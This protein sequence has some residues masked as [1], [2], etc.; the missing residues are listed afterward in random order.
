MIDTL[1]E[2]WGAIMRNKMRTAATGIAVASG[3]FLLIVLL[4]ASNGI[5]HTLE[6]N[7]EGLSLDAVHIYPGYTSK[8]FHG[9]KEGR[10]IELDDR[11]INMP[12]KRFK[13]NVNEVTATVEQS[14][15]TA[16][17]G[18]QHLNV[19]LTGVYPQQKEI[20]GTK[21]ARGRFINDLDLQQNRKVVVIDNNQEE[22]L[23]GPNVNGIGKIININNSAFTV[24]GIRQRDFAFSS[25]NFIAPFTTVKIIYSKGNNIGE[26][27][28]KSTGLDTEKKNEKFEGDYRKAMSELHQFDPKDESAIWMWNSAENNSAMNTA[29]STLHTAFWI[30]GLLTLLSGVVGVSNIMLISVKERTHEF[31]IRKALGARPLSIISMVIFESIII[32]TIFGYIGMLFGVG[33]CEWMDSS[34]GGYTMDIGVFQQ[35][36]FMDPTVD[37][38]TCIEATIV[39][40]VS[41][42]L[43]GFFP[44]QRAAKV[45]PIEALHG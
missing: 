24:V 20:D 40:I 23:F 33:F 22:H 38:G 27:T 16:S 45:K 42:A 5:I 35:K 29:K 18:K 37:L 26:L 3:I 34:V 32:T 8:P 11:D 31:G 41:G 12:K 6:Q 9:I 25:S 15:L 39:M 2:I 44:A 30:L 1:Q 10:R 7:S 43:A 19:T 28:L 17:V 13:E 36:L 14:G 21:L 4:G